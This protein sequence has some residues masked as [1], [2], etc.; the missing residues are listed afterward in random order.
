MLQPLI[1]GHRGASDH[2]PENTLIAF[3]KAIA[4]GADGI[5][6][7]VQLARDGVPV[8]IHDTTLKRT[9][10]RAGLMG[11]MASSE[12]QMIDVGTWFNIRYPEHARKEFATARIP[13][14]EAVLDRFKSGEAMLY[15]ELKCNMRASRAV[16]RAVVDLIREYHFN[17]RAVVLS[18]A[19]ESI[20]E[21]KQIDPTIRTAALFEPKLTRPIQKRNAMIDKA[22]R[23]QAD[24]I[25]LHRSLTTS[26]V[27]DQARRYGLQVVVWTANHPS[28]IARALKERIHAVITNVP[29]LMCAERSKLTQSN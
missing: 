21:I 6:F 11:D 12:L 27:I 23:Y 16:A 14:L 1:I 28:W 24:E 3:D 15:I 26:R 22:V 8:V 4:D 18:F 19:L 7:D 2:T 9:G 17:N 25:A 5:E 13:T 29:A 10:L 20:L